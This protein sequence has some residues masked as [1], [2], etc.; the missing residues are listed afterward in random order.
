MIEKQLRKYIIPNI[1]AMIGISCYILADTFFISVAAGT[2]GI[3]AL[4]LTLPLYGLMFAIG[5]MVGIGSATKYSLAKSLGKKEAEDYFFNSILWTLIISTVFLLSGIFASDKVLIL[6]GADQA[7]LKTGSFYI[8]TALCFAPIFM[9]NYTFTSFVR[10]GNAPKIAMV[11][12]LSSSFFNILFDY[13]FMFPLDMGMF[14]AAL[15]T[16][17]SPI[18]SMAVCMIHFLS[19]ENTIY[20]KKQ[21]PSVSKLISACSLGVAAFVGEISSAVTNLVFNFILLN[22]AGNI[23]VAAYG[24]VANLSLV[25]IAVFNGVSQGLQPMASEAQ[26]KRN[27]DA[28]QRIW[29]HSLQIGIGI[30]IVFVAASFIFTNDIVRIFNSA[31]SKEMAEMAEKGLRLYSIGFLLAAVNIIRAGYFGAIGFAKECFVISISRGIIAIVF[32]AFVLSGL[33]GING[34]WLA[35][36]ASEALTFIVS[37]F[38]SRMSKKKN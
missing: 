33:F 16:G 7:I 14:G 25:G 29:K 30:S 31:N 8:K 2:N 6:M 26:G 3:A 22:L 1:F 23:A 10:N 21:I 17:L 32:F 20:F 34:V 12:T 38:L 13:I 9:L 5:S 11:A 36:P 35:F 15:A 19:K 24:V 28:K 18:V 27:S 37:I 4:N